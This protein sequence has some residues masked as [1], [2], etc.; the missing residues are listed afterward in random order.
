[1]TLTISGRLELQDLL[2]RAFPNVSGIF[3]LCGSGDDVPLFSF[4]IKIQD[5]ASVLMYGLF[6]LLVLRYIE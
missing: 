2:E 5:T 3:M 6:C 1:M 4:N